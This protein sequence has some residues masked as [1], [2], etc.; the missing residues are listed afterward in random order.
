MSAS[1]L[2]KKKKK[3]SYII[4]ITSHLFLHAHYSE[5]YY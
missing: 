4:D 1:L 2:L 5:S 3:K